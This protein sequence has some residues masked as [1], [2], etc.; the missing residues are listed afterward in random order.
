MNNLNPPSINLSHVPNFIDLLHDKSCSTNNIL[1]LNKV[2]CKTN[3]N[4]EYSIIRYD[5][6]VLSPD[7][8]TS[9]GLCRSIIIN[10]KNKVVS[11][12]P[13]KSIP[14]DIFKQK[15]SPITNEIVAEEF[16]EGTMI[17]LFWDQTIGLSGSWEIS[18]RNNVGA[19]TSFFYSKPTKTFRD[20][21]LEAVKANNLD[22]DKL[23]KVYNFSF[24]LQHPEN[25]IVIPVKTLQLYLVSAYSIHH[26][27]DD[28]I[29]IVNHKLSVIKEFKWMNTTIKFPKVYSFKEYSELIDKYSSLDTPYE[30]MGVVI[31][32]ENTFERTKLRNPVYEEIK[33]LRGNQ[34]KLQYQYICLRKEGKVKD[35]LKYYK[36]HKAPFNDF[37]KIIHNFTSSLLNNYISCYVK[38]EKQLLEFPQQYR[39]HMFN[40]HQTYIKDLM[41][42]KLYINKAFVINYINNLDPSLLM[43]SL[44]FNY[45]KRALDIIKNDKNDDKKL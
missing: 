44:N 17:N 13:P 5:K 31:K 36:E 16:V 7:L 38:K 2:V 14:F 21:F 10:D 3:E 30:I 24:V 6:E 4:K 25:R 20:M 40:M 29:E 23:N 33:E 19:N 18:T 39:T 1:K 35:Y 8:V 26:D 34:P 37:K 11:Y 41:E 42:K 15:Y 28:C 32:N 22:L 9:Y 27:S 45:R 12:S 43:Y